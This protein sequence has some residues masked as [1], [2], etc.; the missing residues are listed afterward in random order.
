MYPTVYL[1]AEDRPGLAAG[2][3]L[4][5]EQPVLSVYM[6]KDARGFANLRAK[7]DNYDEM[8]LNGIPVLLLTDLDTDPCPGGK[9]LEWLGRRPSRGFLFRI[10]VREVEAWLLADREA[11][12]RF[13]K[14]RI[15]VVPTEPE[16]LPDPKARLIQ[17]AQQAPRK[18]RNGLTPTGTSSIGPEYNDLLESYIAQDWSIDRAATQAPSLARARRRVAELASLVSA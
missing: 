1:A 18:I 15:S 14:C 16:T 7:V 12:A 3:R 11:M 10:C 5:A 6:E 2:R 13:L 17:L 9:V 8:S 4:I